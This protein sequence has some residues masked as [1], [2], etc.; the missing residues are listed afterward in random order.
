MILSP[1]LPEL[2][3]P[4]KAFSGKVRPASSRLEEGLLGG[5]RPF[6]VWGVALGGNV[7]NHVCTLAVWIHGAGTVHSI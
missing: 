4:E 7:C 6:G 2:L 5:T 3:F 1:S